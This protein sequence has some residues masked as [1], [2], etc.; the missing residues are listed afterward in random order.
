[1]SD[2]SA[3]GANTKGKSAEDQPLED[4]PSDNKAKANGTSSFGNNTTRGED[5]NKCACDKCACNVEI[6]KGGHYC[7]VCVKRCQKTNW[8]WRKM[9]KSL[10]KSKKSG[11]GWERLE[12]E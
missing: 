11:S 10:T 6:R 9:F 5:W 3:Q 4:K 2:S 7:A 8:D 12:E 1:M